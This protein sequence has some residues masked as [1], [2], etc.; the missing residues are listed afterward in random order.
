MDNA[1]DFDEQYA[2][3]V[4]TELPNAWGLYDMQGNVDEWR[5]DRYDSDYYR[6]S[7]PPDPRGPADA[8]GNTSDEHPD[9]PP[10]GPPH[11]R[12]GSAIRGT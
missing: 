10:G 12:V 5:H 1:W 11:P 6:S 3:A 2:H 4:G 8:R 9:P 7:P